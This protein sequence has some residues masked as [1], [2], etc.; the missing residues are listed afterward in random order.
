MVNEKKLKIKRIYSQEGTKLFSGDL[1][2][3][4]ADRP[5]PP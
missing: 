4:R 5:V 1:G 2:A 3:Q